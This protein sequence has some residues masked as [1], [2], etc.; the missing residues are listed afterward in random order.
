METH[1]KQNHYQQ[2]LTAMLGSVEMDRD[3]MNVES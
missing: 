3:Q 1:K 2:M